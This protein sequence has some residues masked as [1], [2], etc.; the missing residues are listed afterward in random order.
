MGAKHVIIRTLLTT[1]LAAVLLSCGSA[2]KKEPTL[3]L[4]GHADLSAKSKEITGPVFVAVLGKNPVEPGVNFADS[5][6]ALVTLDKETSD[7]R[8][9][10]S[11]KGLNPGDPVYIVAFADN[12]WNN[13][14]PNPDEGDILGYYL[15]EDTLSPTYVLSE[16]ENTGA[17]IR[18]DKEVF[19][20]SASV[21]GEATGEGTGLLTVFA[22]AGDISTLDFGSFDTDAILGY[23]QVLKTSDSVAYTLTILPYGRNV[24]I[25]NVYIIGFL[26]KNGNGVPDAGDRI[27]FHTEGSGLPGLVTIDE[28]NL[29][30]CGIVLSLDIP[31]PS[32]YPLSMSGTV[33]VADGLSVG[34]KNI[35]ILVVRYSEN[36]DLDGL[37]SG[38]LSGVAYFYKIPAGG[39]NFAFDLSDSGLAPGER[40]MVLALCDREY[41]E[42]FPAMNA[43]DYV[44]YYQNKKTMTVDLPLAEGLNRVETQGDDDFTIGRVLVSHNASICFQ[45]DDTN[46]ENGPGVTLDPG[47]H[48]TAVAVYKD[49][50]DINAKTF[51]MDYVIGL[52]SIYIPESGNSRHTY[53]MDLLPAMDHRIP[54]KDPFEIDGVYVFAIFDGNYGDGED[55]NNYLGFYW[56]T[57]FLFFM[58]P[59]EIALLYDGV[60]TLDKTVRFTTQTM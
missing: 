54:V 43:G 39:R 42:G 33:D 22:Y 46:L 12:D 56:E 53:S 35:F 18:V 9:D 34:S 1:V 60:T 40:V 23:T 5:L 20:Y 24:P 10:L 13:G 19:S 3:V 55:K 27:G 36:L 31:E 14:I 8:I 29:S 16:G 17:D 6:V 44:G 15:D 51:D 30:G 32:G 37:L 58:Y 41:T 47:E 21:S 49:G 7:F 52:A 45:L 59:R 2:A 11:G 50:V 4:S 26:D 25:E 38:D 28:G 48:V 57:R